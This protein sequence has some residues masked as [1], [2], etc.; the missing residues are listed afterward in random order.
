LGKLSISSRL[1]EF[2]KKFWSLQE[3]SLL[4]GMWNLGD[5]ICALFV[6]FLEVVGVGA[7][8]NV[9]GATRNWWRMVE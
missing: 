2:C 1:V 7:K 4:K 9:G 5:G 8:G 6:D 3:G